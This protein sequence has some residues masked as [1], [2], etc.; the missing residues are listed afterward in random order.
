M[1]PRCRRGVMDCGSE[2]GNAAKDNHR[3][4]EAIEYGEKSVGKPRYHFEQ[5]RL[6]YCSR[7]K[8]GCILGFHIVCLLRIV[9]YV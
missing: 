9:R 3:L 2:I 8:A 6:K 1:I 5:L 4:A 7:L